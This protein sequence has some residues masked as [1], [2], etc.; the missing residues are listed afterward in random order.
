MTREDGGKSKRQGF[1]TSPTGVQ[2]VTP[3]KVNA[4][5]SALDP[6]FATL[7]DS[8]VAHLWVAWWLMLGIEARRANQDL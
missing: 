6:H 1:V 2:Q 5:P 4:R 3:F 8:I 7:I